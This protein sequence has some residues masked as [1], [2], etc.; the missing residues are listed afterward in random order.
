MSPT[1]P[2]PHGLPTER[3]AG[4][5]APP[6]RITRLR[7]TRPVSPIVFP[8]G[9]EGWL[10]T[11]YDAARRLL[12]D[13]RF[14]SRHDLDIVHMP[15]KVSGMPFATE[16]APQVPGLFITMDPP[17]HTRL[18]RKLTG[19]FTT[20]RM[21][22]LEDRI[23]E[24]VEQQLDELTRLTPP[25]DLVK[26][27]ALPVPL[28]VIC[29]LL[30]IP[31]TD[32]E[33]FQANCTKFMEKEATLDEKMAAYT[34]LTTY[35]TELV[36]G[37]R[38]TPGEDILSDLARQD[39]LTIDE[40]TGIAFLLLLAGHETTA[41]T[42]G[43]GTFALLEHPDELTALRNDP[44]LLP[45]AVEELI[46]SLAVVD[47]AFRYA[48]EDIELGGQT[49]TRGSTVIVSI[50]A[51]NHDP[52]RFDH[53]ATLDFHRTARGQLGFGHGIHQCL[54]AQ[55]ARI[56]IRSGLAGLLRRLPTL[57]LAVPAREVRL[58]TDMNIYGVHELPVTWTEP[59]R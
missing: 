27:F 30:G 31:Y 13:T 41:N 34:G 8:D 10:V 48:T 23:N 42:L 50:L 38:A 58:K 4:P 15:Y 19:T 46:R 20:K 44:E 18:R 22:I 39:D 29:E 14:S 59:A 51:A 35:L 7:D 49:I 24:I 9:H 53:P 40:L 5:F 12:A 16:P 36:T 2:A 45:G 1:A 55:L 32:Q 25:V 3:D 26:A 28:L 33:T 17:D 52:Q 6:R 56:E 37:K 57:E 21:K 47:I 54:G 43:L 11:G